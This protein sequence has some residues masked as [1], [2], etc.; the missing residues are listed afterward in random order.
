MPVT[1]SVFATANIRLCGLPF[2]AGF[3]SKDI[4]LELILIRA[5]NSFIFIVILISTALTVFYSYRLIFILRRNY[6]A[7]ESLTGIKDFD[8]NISLGLLTLFFPSIFG[9]IL[10]SWSLFY[11]PQIIFL[12][13]IIKRS[14]FILV[15]ISIIIIAG[16]ISLAKKQGKRT[17][18]RFN[19]LMWFLPLVFSVYFS[20][21][22][23]EKAKIF[24]RVNEISWNETILYKTLLKSIKLAGDSNKKLISSLFSKR[25]FFIFMILVFQIA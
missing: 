15:C 12:S 1:L 19:S 10:L 17:L 13:F 2:M 11:S 14:I 23:L 6:I 3:Y 25:I 21:I 9:G 22:N 7:S 18:T 4:I 16:L 20:I 8:L 24:I 5:L